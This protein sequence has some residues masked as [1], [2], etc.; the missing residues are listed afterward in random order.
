MKILLLN[1]LFSLLLTI[2][3]IIERAQ[4]SPSG[5]PDLLPFVAGRYVVYNLLD[6]ENRSAGKLIYR[7]DKTVTGNY[8][9]ERYDT[10]GRLRRMADGRLQ[11]LGSMT[12]GDWTPKVLDL[13]QAYKD[14][15]IDVV[16]N[17]LLYPATPQDGDA[18]L[19]GRF[20]LT[21][22]DRGHKAVE[23]EMTATERKV[24]GQEIVRTV[25]GTYTAYKISF[26]QTIK[27]QVNGQVCTPYILRQVEWLTPGIGIVKTATYA[28]N[29]GKMLY[30]SVIAAI[31][32][33]MPPPE[34]I[35]IKPEASPI[36]EIPT[37]M[38]S[39]IPPTA[40]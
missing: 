6:S 30:G 39:N 5:C 18:L 11:C 3:P 1:P 31:G 16:N 27:T 21:V 36:L 12:G 9:I 13:L 14:K 10:Y 17:D 28:L 23:L 2:T 8:K 24:E 35:E 20:Q 37:E 15:Q 25:S 29:S 33:E 40:P 7:Y 26:V 22:N 38:P 34:N 4:T 32:N 19:D